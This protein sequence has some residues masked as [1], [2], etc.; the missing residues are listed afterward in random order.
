MR[1]ISLALAAMLGLGLAACGEDESP[2]DSVEGTGGIGGSG[3]SGGS[4]GSGGDG[5]AGG[6]GG[7]AGSGGTGGAGGGAPAGCTPVELGPDLVGMSMATFFLQARATPAIDGGVRTNAALELYEWNAVTGEPTPVELGTFPLGEGDNADYATCQHCVL[8]VALDGNGI[9]QRLFFQ[10]S[11]EIELTKYGGFE[12][13]GVAAGTVRDVALREIVPLGDG[14]FEK[15][16]ESACYWIESWS[17]DTTPNNGAPCERAEDCANTALQVCNPT[18]G[19]CTYS[20]CSFTG[21]VWCPEGQ[22]CVSQIP[23]EIS[24]GACYNQCIP[25]TSG[26]CGHE[27]ACIPLGPAQTI[28]ICKALGPAA[29]GESCDEPDI[30]TG[31]EAG[32][33][34]A[35]DPPVCT[36]LC[37]SLTAAPG[38]PEGQVC[39][40]DNVCTSPDDGDLAALGGLCDPAST[41]ETACGADDQAFRGICLSLYPDVVEQTCHELCRTAEEA[42]CGA[43]SY[44]APLFSNP[45]LGICWVEPVCGDGILDPLNEA[46]DDGNAVGSDGCTYDCSAAEFGPLCAA[47]PSL[48]LGQMVTGTTAGGPTGF[49]ASCHLYQVVPSATYQ[50]VPPGP[51]TLTVQ[52]DSA[53]ANLDVVVYG[54]CNDPMTEVACGSLEEAGTAEIVEIPFMEGSTTP[55]FVVVNGRGIRD[56]GAFELQAHFTP[57]VCGDGVVAG[58][59]RCDDGNTTALDGCSAD[60]TTVEWEQLCAAL[61]PLL[62]DTPI[63]GNTENGADN[64]EGAGIC[65]AWAGDG[66]DEMFAFTAPSDGTLSLHLTEETVDHVVYVV[67]GCGPVAEWEDIVSCSNFGRPGTSGYEELQ[68]MLTAGQ[69]VTVVVEGF[70]PRE[71]G[72]YVLTA[73]FE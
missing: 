30:S 4:G 73:T 56:E 42:P 27:Q 2:K 1:A 43:G 72:P 37:P 25:F 9:A 52:V 6:A 7:T 35:G 19:L 34:C 20:Q 71:R 14:T 22:I 32:A 57:A 33:V 55:A 58:P 45:D 21:D 11:G 38:C 10:E 70:L 49:A 66:W 13:W 24:W 53:E 16:E 62:L 3:A 60:C 12:D 68:V 63:V 51:G 64:L 31:C 23:D 50:F 17:F 46:C 59:E 15:V 39:G 41:P 69:E 47:A 40:M 36:K 44:C 48:P 26:E 67:D 5:G 65:A 18:T 61:D 8:L 54:D 29:L 28:G